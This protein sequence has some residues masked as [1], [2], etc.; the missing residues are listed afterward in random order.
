MIAKKNKANS[1]NNE[2]GL[3]AEDPWV[4]VA[5]TR[6]SGSQRVLAVVQPNP[7]VA[8]KAVRRRFTAEYKRRILTLADAC[9]ETGRLGAL[10]RRE[11]LYA[12]NL[13]TGVNKR[14]G[15]YCRP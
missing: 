10:D 1:G 3:A 8:D 9:T 13:I 4:D 5:K 11:G 12:S 7:E 15:A 6:D 14:N 2:A